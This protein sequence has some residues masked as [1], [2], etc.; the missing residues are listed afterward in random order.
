MGNIGNGKKFP[1]K[2]PKSSP[3][4]FPKKVPQKSSPK[5]SQKI[6]NLIEE[7]PNITL[8]EI[9]DIIGISYRAA[10]KNVHNLKNQGKL[11]RIGP[12]RGG[13]WEI[14]K[15]KI[16]DDSQTSPQKKVVRKSNEIQNKFHLLI[17]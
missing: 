7:K 4:K 2:F 3:K 6:L 10:K 15:Q 16:P 1:N 11:R 9:S 14:L 17:S 12:N 8:R 5:S 13:H